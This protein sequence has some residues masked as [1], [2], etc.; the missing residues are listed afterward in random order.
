MRRV[1]RN[2]PSCVFESEDESWVNPIAAKSRVS[3][4]CGESEQCGNNG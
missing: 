3:R 1:Y 2:I 4:S